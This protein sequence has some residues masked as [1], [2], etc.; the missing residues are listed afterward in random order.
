MR[1]FVSAL[2]I[3]VGFGLGAWTIARLVADK[4]PPWVGITLAMVWLFLLIFGALLVGS[5]QRQKRDDQR[6]LLGYGYSPP[7]S[8]RRS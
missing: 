3:I 1:L 5:K 8:C 7:F 6:R 2:S 4:A